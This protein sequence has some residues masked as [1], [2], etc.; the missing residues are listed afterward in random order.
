M[1]EHAQ[2][3]LSDVCVRPACKITPFCIEENV[4][5]RNPSFLP[6]FLQR[7]LPLLLLVSTRLPR[8]GRSVFL[9][10]CP[11][12]F[13]RLGLR[14]TARRL[15]LLRRRRRRQVWARQQWCSVAGEAL[16]VIISAR[17]RLASECAMLSA[18]AAARM[19]C[20]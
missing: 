3:T 14:P 8:P 11:A 6:S 16:L 12:A 4:Q 10:A 20:E 2:G 13:A 9:L 5:K 17:S 18:S 7:V 19:K 1:R 15:S